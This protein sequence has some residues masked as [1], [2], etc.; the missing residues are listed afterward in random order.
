MKEKGTKTRKKK[1][2]GKRDS[3]TNLDH[4]EADDL[5]TALLEAGDDLADLYQTTRR[6][7]RENEQFV[8]TTEEEQSDEE[9]EERLGSPT[10]LR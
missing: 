6:E 7:S 4:L 5:E 2:R 1:V 10:R 8:Q 3:S 9:K